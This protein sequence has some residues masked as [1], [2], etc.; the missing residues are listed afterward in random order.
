MQTRSIHGILLSALAMTTGAACVAVVG[1]LLFFGLGYL[2]AC[3]SKLTLFQSICV[4]IG[5]TVA[6]GVVAIVVKIRLKQSETY[7]GDEWDD[8]EDDYLDEENDEEEDDKDEKTP[9]IEVP[10]HFQR[11]PKIGRNEPCPCGS[12]R[13]FKMCCAP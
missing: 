10:Q 4:T 3:L 5:S 11:T 7:D 8:E 13:K 9:I 6:L 2:L 12:G 1:T